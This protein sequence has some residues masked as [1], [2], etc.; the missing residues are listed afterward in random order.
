[1]SPLPSP[2]PWLGALQADFARIL[3]EPLDSETG[4]LRAR[5]DRYP[6]ALLDQLDD[7]ATARTR[8]QLYQEQYW[9]RLFTALQSE[10]PRTAQVLGYW[11]FNRVSSAWL[12]ERPPTQADLARAADGLA[13][14][15]LVRLDGLPDTAPLGSALRDQPIDDSWSNTL[16]NTPQPV[17]L[18][19]QALRID[20]AARVAWRAPWTGIWRPS[21][22]ELGGLLRGRLRIAEGLRLLRED[23]ALVERGALPDPA[24][25]ARVPPLERH[26]AP[27]YF[28]SS[29][30]ETSTRMVRIEGPFFRLLTLSA[31]H[32]FGP[33]L[34]RLEQDCAPEDQARLRA[35]VPGWIRQALEAG[36]W[37][38]LDRG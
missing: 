31:Q 4:T 16:G 8:L 11:T 23:W 5:T 26:G 34:E 15:L 19:R 30:A 33:S 17:A 6:G 37:V 36:W 9:Q 25:H 28:V 3:Q 18:V 2:P 22:E 35:A 32:P 7:P 14:A 13:A 12:L 1:M 29:R 24:L 21:P 27:R 20:E 38:G 10:L